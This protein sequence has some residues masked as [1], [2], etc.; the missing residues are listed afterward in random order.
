MTTQA[1]RFHFRHKNFEQKDHF[2]ESTFLYSKSD[3]IDQLIQMILDIFCWRRLDFPFLKKTGYQVHAKA[4][5]PIFGLVLVMGGLVWPQAMGSLNS[6]GH[7]NFPQP[8]QY[9]SQWQGLVFHILIQNVW[10]FITASCTCVSTWLL[11]EDRII[12]I[13]AWAVAYNARGICIYQILFRNSKYP[14]LVS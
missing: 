8:V 6:W 2:L 11:L 7:W 3:M 1:K 14:L 5:G 10:I 12:W 9:V 13:K 4:L